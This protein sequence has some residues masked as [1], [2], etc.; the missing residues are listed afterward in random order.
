MTGA[1]AV[2]VGSG[3]IGAATA[4]ELARLGLRTVVIDKAGGPGYGSTSA[5]SA[6]VRFNYSTVD[7]VATAWEARH[8]WQDWA[9]HLGYRD[10]SGLASFVRIGTLH[11]DSPVIERQQSLKLLDEVGV[12]YQEYD[13]DAL[14]VA[15]PWL[16]VGRYWPNKKI[17]D[18]EFWAE[19]SGQLGG[20]LMLDGGYIDDPQL[21]A[22]N[23]AAAARHAGARFMFNKTVIGLKQDASERWVV[24]LENGDPITTSI[25]VNVAGPWSSHVNRLAGVGNDFAI[26]VR[27][28][29]QEVHEVP[30]PAAIDLTRNA[31]PA[32]A[33]LDLG[34]YMRP[35]P[36]GTLLIG[37]TEPKCD[38]LEW[39][40]DPDT[41]NPRPTVERFEAQV[42]RAARRIPS[43][44]VPRQPKGI[45][46][47]YD[48]ADDWTPIYDRTDARGFYVAMGT[49]GNQFKNAPVAGQIMAAIVDAVENGHDHDADPV[50]FHA[51]HTGSVINLGVFSRKRAHNLASSGTVLG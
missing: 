13:S 7:G 28:L 40:D 39:L 16:D 8:C 24:Q 6:L 26:R 12:P 5:S 34:T 9:E 36:N 15:F 33:D 51:R 19:S 35:G 32:I 41:S 18:A 21:A 46:G 45:A 22:A 48:A 14:H 20:Y 27:P 10:P 23:L 43:L 11:L 25:V 38:P 30:V 50:R 29:R 2:V 37:G 44:G 49:S 3:V 42:T 31:F 17:T 47:V 1:D 4:L